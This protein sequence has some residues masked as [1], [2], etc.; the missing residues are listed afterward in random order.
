MRCGKKEDVV[1]PPPVKI[2]N[3]DG[4]SAVLVPE[5]MILE[6][7]VIFVGGEI[8]CKAKSWPWEGNTQIGSLAGRF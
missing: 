5:P 1:E 3:Y 8:L 2:E 4:S 6:G 7:G